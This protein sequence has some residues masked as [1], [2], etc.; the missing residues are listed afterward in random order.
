MVFIMLTGP[1]ATAGG[2][3]SESSRISVLTCGPGADLYSSFGHTAIRVRDPKTG[4][5]AVFNYGTFDSSQDGFFWKF[6]TG[7]ILYYLSV[8]SF[9]KFCLSYA[10]EDR[11][12]W[13]Q[14]LNLSMDVKQ[15]I[16]GKLLYDS[17]EENRYYRYNFMADNCTTRV[18]NVVDRALPED[19]ATDYG[20]AT[21]RQLLNRTLHRWEL[22]MPFNI[23]MGMDADKVLTG[24][25]YNCLPEIYMASL[26][27]SL[28]ADG[29]PLANPAQVV[30]DGGYRPSQLM[31]RVFPTG[32]LLLLAVYAVLNAYV[33]K[34]LGTYMKAMLGTVMLLTGCIGLAITFLWSVGFTLAGPN[35]NLLWAS[36]ANLF[37]LPFVFRHGRLRN[38]VVNCNI[39]LTAAA[40]VLSVF[41]VQQSE[42]QSASLLLF[43]FAT[44]M[45]CRATKLP[46]L[47]TDS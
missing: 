36:P 44:Y 19:D 29:T 32:L 45:L 18:L 26:E 28:L 4:I 15:A 7:E 39:L 2:R 13:E 24:S 8:S 25:A 31:F 23:L 46:H 35:I 27:R 38:I 47:N 21:F 37:L 17:R 22:R 12:V 1:Y 6:L 33:P 10:S 11:V 16:F 14:R 30:V 34:Y 3:L 43:V 40:I 20:S 9:E 41:G 42:F 5:D